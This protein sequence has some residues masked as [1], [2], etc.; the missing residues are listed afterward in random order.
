M[1]DSYNAYVFQNRKAQSTLRQC[2][3]KIAYSLQVR[4]DK[5]FTNLSTKS[6]VLDWSRMDSTGNQ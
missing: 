4:I 6:F 3:K 2:E 5:E 1:I